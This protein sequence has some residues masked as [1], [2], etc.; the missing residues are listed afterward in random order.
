MKKRI[1]FFHML[2]DYSGSPHVLS[3]VI[4]GLVDKDYTID[5][6]TSSATTGF[7]SSIDGIRYHNVFYK[8]TSNKFVTFFL[9]IYAQIL[10]FFAVIKLIRTKHCVIYI[11][12]ILPFGA[13]V[14]ALLA[15]KKVIYH[16][17]EK[18]VQRNIMQAICLFFFKICA[19]KAIFVS[20]YLFNSI[21]ILPQKKISIYNALSNNFTSKA[22]KH[23]PGLHE[24]YQILMIC[25]LR[26]YKGV[27]VFKEAA[28][29]LS[30]YK[31]F[32][33]LNASD[34]EIS[35]F[36]DK[37]FIPDN[38][39]ILSAQSDLHPFYNQAHLL[40]NLSIPD[41]WVE[42][43]GLTALEAMSYGIPVI[44]PP[45]GGISEI[46]DDGIQGFKVDSRN[47]DLVIQA[48]QKVFLTKE[49]YY[50][51]SMEAKWKSE[52]FSLDTM[53]DSIETVI[54]SCV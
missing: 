11:N 48:I 1:V 27:N 14:G 16:V 13:A 46:V 22:C 35:A 2:N 44:V 12:T 32:L 28:L 23:T 30:N 40:L 33:I 5:L 19:H 31:F 7:L 43:F 45:V 15:C 25:S 18:P 8:F 39:F 54:K 47:Q 4:K 6:Y 17:H 42:T 51:M 37:T 38:L 41:L 21:E 26:I 49:N 10:Y 34:K 9:F 53:I 29:K 36:F 50:R 20:N 3:L 24:P 52:L